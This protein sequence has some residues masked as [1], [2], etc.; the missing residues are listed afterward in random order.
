[1][2]PSQRREAEVW[3]KAVDETLVDAKRIAVE[4]HTTP[5]KVLEMYRDIFLAEGPE[6]ASHVELLDRTMSV[7]ALEAQV[8]GTVRG[9]DM[10]L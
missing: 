5:R 3:A 10:G 7:L 6:R 2:T 9:F 8:G 1:V 4:R